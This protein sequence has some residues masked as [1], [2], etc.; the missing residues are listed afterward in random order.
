[1][2]AGLRV[3]G[4]TLEDLV[5]ALRDPNGGRSIETEGKRFFR[6]SFTDGRGVRESTEEPENSQ[7][8]LNDEF[9]EARKK[10]VNRELTSKRI[11][12]AGTLSTTDS[13]PERSAGRYQ[14]NDHRHDG[15][16]LA[17]RTENEA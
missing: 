3:V 11:F 9:Q 7:K 15:Y 17:N 16:T 14:R 8:M 5:S 12:N 2:E 4:V 10:T 1:M 6:Q 13:S